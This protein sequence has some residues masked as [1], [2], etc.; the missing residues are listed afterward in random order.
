MVYIGLVNL[1]D[2]VKGWVYF[3]FLLLFVE[4][5][6]VLNLNWFVILLYVDVFISLSGIGMIYMVMIICMI[7]VMECNNMMLKMFGNVY[8]IYGVLC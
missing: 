2:V 3:N 7:Y 4:F 1:V 6:I 5:V 8:L